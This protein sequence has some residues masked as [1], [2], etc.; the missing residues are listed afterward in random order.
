MPVSH[1]YPESDVAR[2]QLL[3]ELTEATMVGKR[4]L[5]YVTN[6]DEA[7]D[8]LELLQQNGPF[9]IENVEVAIPQS[10]VMRVLGPHRE[11]VVRRGDGEVVKFADSAV[12]QTV[13]IPF[14]PS[15]RGVIKSVNQKSK[16]NAILVFWNPSEPLNL[17]QFSCPDIYVFH[18]EVEGEIGIVREGAI[19][20]NPD[21]VFIALADQPERHLEVIVDDLLLKGCIELASGA[22]ESYKTMAAIAMCAGILGGDTV[23]DHFKVRQ[24]YPITFLCPDMGA[25]LFNE[26]AAPFNLRGFGKDFCVQ[27]EG[28]SVFHG[29]DSPV[30]AAHIKGRILILDTML[31]YAQ[32]QKAFESNEWVKFFTKLRA[33]INVHGCVAILMLAHPTKSGGKSDSIEP[34][35]YLKDSVTFGG[36]ID[37]GFAF[38]KLKESS[39]IFVKRIKG[40]GFK[41]REFTFTL[42]THDEAGNS[43]LDQGRFPVYLK[44]GEAGRKED[45]SCKAGRKEDSQKKEKLTYLKTLDGSLVSKVTLLN[46]K[47]KSHHTRDTVRG[48]LRVEEQA[49]ETQPLPDWVR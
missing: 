3:Q 26:Y 47:F 13:T 42:T 11:L 43:Y 33:L 49:N 19:E 21:E 7:S 10:K 22:F 40:R 24:R 38:S 45:Y 31:D 37:V 2:D 32:I 27:R 1:Y 17:S 41:Q 4:V 16:E 44:P 48:W 30:L 20:E 46:K 14:N 9:C 18:H 35:D 5:A 12:E 23:F 34:A 39:Q 28:V 6:K 25:D 8:F 29:V 36:K 15:D